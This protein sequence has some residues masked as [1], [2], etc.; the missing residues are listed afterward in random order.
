[1]S[2]YSVSQN[3]ITNSHTTQSIICQIYFKGSQTPLERF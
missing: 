3:I 2:E 1:M